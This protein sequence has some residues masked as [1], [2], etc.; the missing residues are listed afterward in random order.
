MLTPEGC[1]TRRQRLWDALPSPCDVLIVSDPQH[2]I[3]FANYE[4]SPFVFRAN[5][6]GAL[7]VLE[8]GK[9]TL[10]ADSML[11]PFCDQA[12]VD[13]VVAPDWYNGKTSAP[14]RQGL[15][16]RT[17]LDVLAQRHGRRIGV[18]LGTAPGGVLEG[19]RGARPGLELFDLDP[20]IRPLKRAKD[21]DELDVLRRSFRAGEAGHAAAMAGIQPGMTELDAYLLVQS[22]AIKELGE[23]AIVYGDFASGT[24]CEIE[25]GGPPTHRTIERGDLFL[26][27][28]SVIVRGYRGDF[29]NT[30]AVGSRATARQRELFDACLGALRAGEA[31]LKPGTPGRAVDEAVHAHFQA[32]GLD[33]YFPS[34]TGHG[35][36]LGHPDPP[37]LVPESTDTLIAGDVVTLEPGLYIRGEGGMRI[38]HNYLITANGFETL[39]HHRL[40]IDV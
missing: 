7:L 15:L 13:E 21:A 40:A 14:H 29:T 38:E 31:L 18:E 19:L 35:I 1:A 11:R 37:Y 12:H 34:H 2:L 8:P 26:L 30:F 24:R 10:V 22:A 9:A 20:V 36:G 27:D 33:V 25:R 28:Y 23:P 3:Y 32:L 17:A 6:A 5:D 16:V 39:T 4:T